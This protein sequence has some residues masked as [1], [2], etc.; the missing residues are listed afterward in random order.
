MHQE[1]L[2]HAVKAA[3]DYLMYIGYAVPGDVL[4]ALDETK[5]EAFY[6]QALIKYVR[7]FYTGAAD[8]GETIDRFA[9][10][11]E[12][13]FGRAWREGMREAGMAPEDMTDEE[14][15][16]LEAAINKEENFVLDYL[17]D[18]DSARIQQKPIEPLL[19][20]VPLWANRYNQIKMDALT[21]AR[22]DGAL[23]WILGETEQHCSS[24]LKLNGIVKRGSFW[25]T[26]GV[27]PQ[28]APNSSLECGGWRCDCRL[29]PTDKPLRRGPLP[30]LP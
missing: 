17:S 21:M 11:I 1:Q 22:A 6:R 20:R 14:R 25:R 7:D 8:V 26:S 10:M 16:A 12:E 18:I 4:E 5:T 28:N 29:E 3:A 24:C 27:M 15:Q 2:I 19:S 13:Q 23:I 30:R 9:R